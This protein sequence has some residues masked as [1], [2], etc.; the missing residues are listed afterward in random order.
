MR[1]SD[2]SSDVCSS[3]LFEGA[4]MTTKLKLL[5]VDVA[6]F[7]DAFATTPGALELVFADAVGGVYKK[8]VVLEKDEP[9][10]GFV[11]LGGILVG[12]ASAYGILRP[13]VSSG[14][15]LPE[16]PEELILPAARTGGATKIGMPDEAVVCSCNNI[17]SEEHTS[18]LQS[19]MR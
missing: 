7:G 10:G 11:L 4:D 2:W 16:N 18:E 12:D 6:S 17:R 9:E 14:M 15:T 1:I 5:G 13:M 8:L 19:L 3:D